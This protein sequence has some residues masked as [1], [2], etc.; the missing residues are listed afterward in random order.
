MPFALVL[1][2]LILIV[3]GARNTHTALGRQL[4]SD[5]TGPGN[6]VYWVLAIGSVGAL[7]YIPELR[8]FSRWFMVLIIVAMVIRNGGFFDKF[9]EAINQG[10][11]APP[12]SELPNTD[13]TSPQSGE[14]IS[15]F[16]PLGI[17]RGPSDLTEANRKLD[18][19][20]R[21]LMP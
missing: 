12:V 10:P 9:R 11:E 19:W 3:S 13:T 4:A 1:I 21:F 6:F 7:G 16:S 18:G 8:S 2:G 15:S 20:F 5:F 17:P 14:P